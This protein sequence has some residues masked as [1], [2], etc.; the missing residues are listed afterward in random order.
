MQSRPEDRA[1]FLTAWV[2]TV[3]A[4]QQAAAEAG[5]PDVAFCSPIPDLR[6][7]KPTTPPPLGYMT[8]NKYQLLDPRDSLSEAVDETINLLMREDIIESDD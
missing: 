4:Y 5:A 6:D 2:E 1:T 7:L 8:M 3:V